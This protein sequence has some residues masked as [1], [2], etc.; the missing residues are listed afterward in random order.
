VALHL[1]HA[2]RPREA[3][4]A[5]AAFLALVLVVD[6]APS[7]GDDVGGIFTLAPV[8]VLTV[9]ALAGRRLTWRLVLGAALVALLVLAAAIGLDLLRPPESR[10][11]LGRL[12]AD[13]WRDGGDELFTTIGRKIDTNLRILRL[14]PWIWAVPVVCAFLFYLL[15]VRRRW[16]ELLPPASPL[17]AGVLGALAAGV[18]GFLL[19]DSGVVV[20]ALVLVEVGPLFAL[21]SLQGSGDSPVL[22]EPYGPAPPGAAT[23][24]AVPARGA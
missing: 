16:N 21:L 15:R 24:L 9:V 18:L 14:T 10:T 11:H 17:R 7:L 20:M 3:L 5:G 13:T 8:F 12:V 22:L 1:V 6:A 2:P 4:A 23:T 19:N